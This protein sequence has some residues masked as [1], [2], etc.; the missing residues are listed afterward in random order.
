MFLLLAHALQQLDAVV[1][2]L[3]GAFKAAIAAALLPGLLSRDGRQQREIGFAVAAKGWGLGWLQR[4]AGAF[5]GFGGLAG[6]H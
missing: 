3:R 1:Q 5:K 2:D 4:L 6:F